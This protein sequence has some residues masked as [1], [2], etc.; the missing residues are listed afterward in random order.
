MYRYETHLHTALISACS[1]FLPS[2]IVEKYVRL[3]YSGIFVTDHFLNGNTTVPR[4]LPWVERIERFTEGF[5]RVKKEAA[6]K[7]DVFFGF[8]YSYKGTDFL[9][10]GLGK[11]W[12]R[13]HPEIM[14]Q[15][16]NEFCRFA[17]A[18]GGLVLQAH[19]FREA[20]YIDHIRLFPSVVD[21]IETIN[22]NRNERTNRLADNLAN[23]Y[24]LIK[25]AGSDI[26]T[27][28][29]THLAGVEFVRKIVSEHDFTEKL[30]AGEGKL[31]TV[32]EQ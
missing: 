22:A 7:L 18:E 3:K 10:Y 28:T 2:E 9:V 8:E 30:K 1:R 11:D 20:D 6:D 12:L 13:N 25:T 24:Q 4:D 16:V 5:E 17:R 27:S 31:F 21:G 26:H 14:D 32:D 29:Q 19:P 23:E 15:T